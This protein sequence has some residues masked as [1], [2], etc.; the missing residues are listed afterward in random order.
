MSR[1]ERS[2]WKQRRTKAANESG[3]AGRATKQEAGRS[4]ENSEI[5][6]ADKAQK[7][8]LRKALKN[9]VRVQSKEIAESLIT[10]AMNGDMRGAQVLI[11]AVAPE[12]KTRA[13]KKKWSGP[14]AAELLASEP[15]WEGDEAEGA[16]GMGSGSREPEDSAS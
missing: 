9:A 3:K 10:S 5:A 7:K 2:E 14:S 11:K 16:A 13:A 12:R 1:N 15:E 4:A 8:E 6:G